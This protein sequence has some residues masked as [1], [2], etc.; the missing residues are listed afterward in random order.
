MN[1]YTPTPTDSLDDLVQKAFACGRD[2]AP[3]DS[4]ANWIDSHESSQDL[5]VAYHEGQAEQYEN[6]DW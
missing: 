5:I 2:L 4:R 3:S 1:R 6:E